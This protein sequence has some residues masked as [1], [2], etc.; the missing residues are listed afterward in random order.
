ML[1]RIRASKREWEKTGNGKLSMKINDRI[2]RI[3]AIDVKINIL[4]KIIEVIF[5]DAKNNNIRTKE[6]RKISKKCKGE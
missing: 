1:N 5:F 3:R 4:I 6:C 2:V